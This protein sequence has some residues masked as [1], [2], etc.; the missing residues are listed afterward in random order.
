MQDRKVNCAALKVAN[1]GSM[2][3]RGA[4]DEVNLGSRTGLRMILGQIARYGIV[5]AAIAL[6]PLQQQALAQAIL[7]TGF[8]EMSTVPSNGDLNPYGV[9]FVPDGFPG[10]TLSPGDLLVSNF[11]N[12]QNQQGTGSTIV[13]VKPDGTTS[14]FFQGTPPLGLTTALGV[15][16]SGFVL[17][18]NLPTNTGTLIPGEAGSILVINRQ[19]KQIGTLSDPNLL[20][21]PWDLTI[22]DQ[23]NSAKVFV[24]N[25][26]NG[27]VTR[28]DLAVRGS[29]LGV[30]NKLTIAFGYAFRTD[31]AA[32]VVGPTGLAY[33]AV[34]D[35][36]YVASTGDNEIFKILHAGATNMSVSKGN[37]VYQDNAHLR[38]PLA[39]AFAPNGHL[40]TSNGDAVNPPPA[41]PPPL[42][43]QLVEFTINGQFIG[44]LS[45]DPGPG[46][47]FGLA[48]GQATNAMVRFAAVNDAIN[49]IDVLTLNIP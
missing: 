37:V 29:A 3:G 47:A 15:L 18:G 45:V 41:T 20:D 32:L 30:T 4:A 5:G 23:G 6:L 26:L 46:A 24:S 28:L 40:V 49:T 22:L 16:K 42:P 11:N 2:G 48:F 10:G 12:S 8:L 36:L 13:R 17:V 35:I 31:P 9:A 19:G 38:G 25:V 14:L 43:S 34:G 27:T 39:L 33:D 21:G 44:Q 1:L 7:P